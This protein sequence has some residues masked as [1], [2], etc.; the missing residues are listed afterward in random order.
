VGGVV[1]CLVGVWDDGV[2]APRDTR[3]FL[4][5]ALSVSMTGPLSGTEV[6]IFRK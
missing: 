2:I 3:V 6:G 4:G 5:L 1:S